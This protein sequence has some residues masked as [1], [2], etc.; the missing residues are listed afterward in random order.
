M[1]SDYAQAAKDALEE[2]G[3]SI[4]DIGSLKQDEFQFYLQ[5]TK[6]V[7]YALLDIADSQA[8]GAID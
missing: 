8:N 2:A 4:A 7:V 3:N 1:A 5:L 6:A